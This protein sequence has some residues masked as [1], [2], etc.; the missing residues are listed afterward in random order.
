M[1][2]TISEPPAKDRPPMTPRR[3]SALFVAAI[4]LSSC[5]GGKEPSGP[6]N[7]VPLVAAG[8]SVLSGDNQ[9][10]GAG[11]VVPVAPVVR[12]VSTG[13]TPVGGA[14]LTLAP[15]AGRGALDAT[16][17]VT[18]SNGQATL[19]R[20][21]APLSS[22]EFA[23][24]VSTPGAAGTTVTV[25][26]TASV[27][28]A[29]QTVTSQTL[30]PSG[31]TVAVTAGDSPLNGLR[32]TVPPGTLSGSATFTISSRPAPTPP[33]WATVA[34]P[35]IEI[36]G[37]TALSDS[38]MLVRIP[39]SAG[40]GGVL[41]AF[42]LGEDGRLIPVTAMEADA[43]SVTVALR[44]FTVPA[45]GA[46]A[47]LR[48]D[49][50]TAELDAI[51]TLVLLRY[52]IPTGLIGTGY[53]PVVDNLVFGNDGSFW[54]PGGFCAGWSV[55]AG[56]WFVGLSRPQP[57]S[58]KFAPFLTVAETG[59]QQLT[60]RLN[61]AIRLVT[62]L[63]DKYAYSRATV[64]KWKYV[65]GQSPITVWYNVVVQMLAGRWPVFLA[66]RTADGLNGHAVL[67]YKVD[68]NLGRIYVADPNFPSVERFIQWN[69]S[70]QSFDGFATSVLKGSPQLN[71][72]QFAD[73]TFFFLQ[74]SSAISSVIQQYLTDGLRS[75][76]PPVVMRV[77]LKSGQVVT[78]TDNTSLNVQSR[79]GNLRFTADGMSDGAIGWVRVK[80]GLAPESDLHYPARDGNDVQIPLVT[81]LN[82]IGLWFSKEFPDDFKWVDAK[83]LMI[84]RTPPVLKFLTEPADAAPNQSLGPVRIGLVDEDGTL[85]PEVRGFSLTLTGGAA[86]AVLTGGGNL[87]TAT[88][89]SITLPNLSVNLAGTG[90]K[91][92]AASSGLTTVA[93][94][95]FEIGGG[96][97]FTGR[98]FHAV[99][100]EAIEG[101]AIV[102]Q[103]AGGTQAGSA[104]SGAG[105][106]WSVSGL[107]A[108]TYTIQ[109]S[110][111]GFVST[112]LAE[113]TLV[114]PST[115][116]EP[117]PLVPTAAPGGISGSIRNASTN[118][119]ITTAVTVELREGI[120]TATGTTVRSVGTSSGAYA[121]ADVP[122]GVYTIV[123]RGVGYADGSRTGIVVGAGT[124]VTQ[125]DVL[126]SPSAGA[127]RVVL[128]WGATPRDLDSHLTG[129]LPGSGSRF[130][131]YFSSRGNCAAAP[132]ACLDTDKV[133][134]FGPET[135]T[136]GQVT[137]GVYRYYVYDYTNRG[138]GSSTALGLS[139]A[140][141]Q[142]YVGSTLKQTFFVPSGAGNAWE[143]FSWDGTT[144]TA[145]NRLY[146]ISGG[147][148]QPNLMAGPGASAAEHEL[149]EL[150]GRLPAKPP[151]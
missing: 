118:A 117:I 145:L 4:A 149:R 48:A 33:P 138:D 51:S 17:V 76:Y 84:T 28:P 148:P 131:V 42:M 122:A 54:E 2:S 72:T 88:D 45:L 86:G 147:T 7:P 130:W 30:G 141:V 57:A 83:L 99:T 32:I 56:G 35:L 79:D 43:G 128:T 9:S 68:L 116:V 133:S 16:T 71:F 142:F 121:F 18:G 80:S 103:D 104:T 1:S 31:G 47:S 110:K 90:Y 120:N 11:Q 77:T 5:G 20:W 132:F 113:Q 101:A 12:V 62:A 82:K 81:G 78:V 115:V 37:P 40:T 44:A 85:V 66:I 25:R 134:G 91:L 111:T 123:A 97:S 87:S 29:S 108:G 89:G 49:R 137:P 6:G 124:T 100:S 74:E 22:G 140:R 146:V 127:A 150:I 114:L 61:P 8:I 136:L 58:L 98:V 112:S 94:R 39:A 41:A 59:N 93:S 106:D 69:N 75:Q 126:L 26:V 34:S 139:T 95:S 55:L 50:A 107:A 21:V 23:V 102:V 36:V 38:V 60:D 63:Q 109:A 73:A 14:T 19:P 10:V 92:E 65:F 151:K 70:T 96:G 64:G 46:A 15:D 27:N 3:S 144:V 125:Q 105:G 53:N 119:L 52:L 129:P 67:A 24:T 13:N 143:V 135:M